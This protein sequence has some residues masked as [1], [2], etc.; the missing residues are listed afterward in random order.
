VKNLDRWLAV[1]GLLVSLPG[2][3][4]MFLSTQRTVAGMTVA[5]G[6]ALVVAGFI[7][8][9]ERAKP[10]FTMKAISI[11]L[12][13]V[14]GSNPKEV[15]RITRSYKFVANFPHMKV[16]VNRSIGADGKIENICWDGQP[17]VLQH[18]K[19]QG[20]EYEA[21]VIF[22]EPLI[23][24]QVYQGSL[25]YDAIRAFTG[26]REYLLHVV[27]FETTALSFEILLPDSAPA[28]AAMAFL[29]KGGMAQAPIPEVE[30]LDSGKRIN[31]TLPF[32]THVGNRVEVAWDW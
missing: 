22:N 30:L 25:S 21:T 1:A 19:S 27:D 13:F 14:G 17:V 24:G 11:R 16:L 20:G 28:R 9:R 18:L 8:L 31:L 15:A 32:P 12:E 6:L 10:P 4:L 2:F 23:R 5:L 7:V 3:L 29:R 26:P